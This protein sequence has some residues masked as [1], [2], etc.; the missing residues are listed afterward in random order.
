MV[1]AAGFERALAPRV[2][3]AVGYGVSWAGA[4]DA[5][6]RRARRDVPIRCVRGDPRFPCDEELRF[7]EATEFVSGQGTC[8]GDSGSGAVDVAQRSSVFALL[9]RGVL[10]STSCA[11]GIYVRTDAWAWLIGKTVLDAARARGSPPPGWAAALFPQPGERASDGGFCT[12][13][14][15]CAPPSRCLSA[16]DSRSFVCATPCANDGECSAGYACLNGEAGSFC[17]AGPAPPQASE[18]AFG[19][20]AAGH[21]ASGAESSIWLLVCMFAG[22]WARFARS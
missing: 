19:C 4:G 2:L 9:S 3:G 18:D 5:G 22:A 7:T 15:D 11:D 14:A 13:D 17:F 1:D 10:R 12:H 20:D 16:D 21:R 8:T 6:M